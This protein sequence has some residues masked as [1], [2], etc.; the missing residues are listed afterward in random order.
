MLAVT[1]ALGGCSPG[2]DPKPTPTP[3]FASE[4][5]AY[6]AAEKVYRE[7]VDATNARNDG[8]ESADPR[9]Y[10]AGSAL[11]H[12]VES[13]R[14][15]QEGGYSITGH[16]T[17]ESFRGMETLLE[18][19]TA[20]AKAE[21]CVDGSQTRVVDRAGTDVTPVDREP[22]GLVRVTFSQSKNSLLI[23]SS[24]LVSTQC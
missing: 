23:T 12:A 4:A 7:Y 6:K 19:P 9:K 20:T 24:E 16:S 10:L 13:A 5:D 15:R 2:T 14:K 3:L 22:K 17:V 8:D 21:V 1:L 11:E 18:P